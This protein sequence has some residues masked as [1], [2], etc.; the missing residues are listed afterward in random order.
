VRKE[1]WGKILVLGK[2]EH[3]SESYVADANEV[4]VHAHGTRKRGGNLREA[5]GRSSGG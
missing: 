4:R 5:I 3:E 1:L 2:A